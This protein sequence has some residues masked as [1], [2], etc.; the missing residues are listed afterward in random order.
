MSPNKIII[1]VSALAVLTLGVTTALTQ[2]EAV[3][4]AEMGEVVVE[5]PVEKI[6]EEVVIEEDP[7]LNRNVT[8]ELASLG[9][10]FC[11]NESEYQEVRTALYDEYMVEKDYDFDINNRDLLTEVLNEEIERRGIVQF[12]VEDKEDLKNQLIDLLNPNQ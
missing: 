11:L 6:V 3:E 9:E 4:L 7:C 10:V 5:Q 2:E 1:T 8:I 12:S